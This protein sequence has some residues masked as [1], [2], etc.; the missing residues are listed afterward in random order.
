M[1]IHPMDS[2][3]AMAGATG[4]GQQQNP[5]FMVVWLVLMM[6][7]FYVMLIRPQQRREKQRKALIA[8]VKT[9]DKI[10]FAG[11][12]TGVVANTKEQLLTVKIADNVKIEVLRS[13]VNRVLD[14]GEKPSESDIS[15]K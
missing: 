4:G 8:A 5:A 12:L 7:I 11:G 9:G 1:M 13:S 15:D 10:V 6:G 3:I 14:K 2:I